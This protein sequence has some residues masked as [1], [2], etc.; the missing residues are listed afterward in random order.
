MDRHN[1]IFVI[2]SH[3]KKVFANMKNEGKDFSRK[4]TPL[5]VTMMIQAPEDMGEDLELP[6]DS[7]PTPIVTQPSSSPSQ[8]KQKS[9]RKQ[10]KEIKVPLPI[11]TTAGIKVT[12]A[13]TT[14]QISK[15][16]LTLAWTLIEIKAAKPKA[17]TIVVTV[18]TVA[19]TRPKKGIVM[20]EPSETPSPKPIDSSQKSSKI[21]D[22]GKA[23]M[24]EPEKPLKIKYQIM[25]DE[26][27]ARNLKAQMQA[28]LE[29]EEMLARQEEEETSIALIES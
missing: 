27:V 11:I 19:G 17:I 25:I 5:L 22:K 10:R 16:E 20:Q 6:T 2:S 3:T 1:A 24:I 18:V 28:E 8:K 4:V 29:E 13:A 14:S 21:K 23:K 7:H 9:R 12:I 15:D 26:E